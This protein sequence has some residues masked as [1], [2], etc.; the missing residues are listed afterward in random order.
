MNK[1]FKR[2]MLQGFVVNCLA[3]SFIV[4][5]LFIPSEKVD[6]A[7]AQHRIINGTNVPA[8]KYPWAV[9]LLRTR[10]ADPTDALLCGGT[11][12]ERQWVL[13]AAHCVNRQE[14]RDLQV[15]V[16]LVDLRG[17]V[18]RISVDEI[19][20]H[21][22]IAR[23]GYSDVALLKLRRP[24]PA[25]VPTINVV[26]RGGLPRIGTEL[27]AMGWGLTENAR[28]SPRLKE[29]TLQ[30]STTAACNRYTTRFF[31]AH[32]LCVKSTP[33]R[34]Q[35]VCSGDSGGPIIARDDTSG[36]LYQIGLTSWGRAD[37]N[38]NT[39][40][41]FTRLDVLA[42]WITRQIAGRPAGTEA[43]DLSILSLDYC[44]GLEC[45]FDASYA[46]GVDNR[47]IARY[48]WQTDD[49]GTQS[50]TS[51]TIFIHRFAA[52]GVHDVQ[53]TLVFRNGQRK[54]RNFTVDVQTALATRD[55]H[56]R[57]EFFS[58]SLSGTGASGTLYAGAGRG[59]FFYDGV[60]DFQLRGPAGTDFDMSLRKFNFTTDVWEEVGS[61]MKQGSNERINMNLRRGYYFLLVYSFQ[62]AGA[63]QITNKVYRS[64]RDICLLT[65]MLNCRA[66]K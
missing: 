46:S 31:P 43:R 15:A 49:G 1:K 61:S 62:G 2:Q 48:I 42:P 59:A 5:A 28:I 13:T 37:C 25:S 56:R 6:A 54:T 3:L 52:P 57:T 21:S 50:S 7:S 34:S 51:E 36:E 10:V 38:T 22:N 65:N 26:E 29:A 58:G 55:R 23:V 32:E 17:T 35:G 64:R 63:L 47:P 33:S 18:E 45:T 44:V 12:I 4:F 27:T 53:L 30:L 9:A 66:P 20:A 41:V 40:G 19:I 24:V 16:N 39:A 60:A 8:G 14:P 11:L